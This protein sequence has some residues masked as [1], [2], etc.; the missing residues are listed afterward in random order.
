MSNWTEISEILIPISIVAGLGLVFAAVLAIASVKLRVEEDPRIDQVEA[1]LPHANCGA[2]GEPGC[3]AFAEKLVNG[4]V[5]P[6]KCTVSP[7][8]GLEAIAGLLGVEAGAQ[9]KVVAR[10]LCAGGKREAHHLASYK[11][12]LSTC[13]AE[14][15]VSGGPKACS[16]GCLGLGDC[17]EAC[18]FDAIHMNDDGLPEVD[19]AR[20]TACNDCVEIC[21]KDLF[22]LMPVSHKLIVQC[23][24]LLKGDEA[25]NKCSVA[26]TACG[27][28]VADA[29][30]GLIEI[31]RNLAVINYELNHLANPDIIA[32]CPTDAITWVEERQ[33]T[34][35]QKNWLPVGRIE[36]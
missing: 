21:P 20:C 7:P 14:A 31:S 25:E 18:D 32:R 29:P 28:C 17:A 15:T 12:A 35:L 22:T 13:R 5:T 6:A 8:E 23:K 3:R 9:E 10:L 2:C 33:F 24:S 34:E 26:C 1:L 30:A 36:S 19:P 27:R 16:W 11:G 4:E